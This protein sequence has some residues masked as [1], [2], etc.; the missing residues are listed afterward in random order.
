MVPLLRLWN[1]G[2]L[3]TATSRWL[4]NPGSNAISERLGYERNG[5]AWATRRSQPAVLQR[6]RLTRQAWKRTRRDD[7]ELHGVESCRVA[8]GLDP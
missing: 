2:A 5:T 7:I 4:D 6:W 8:L 1:T 3:W